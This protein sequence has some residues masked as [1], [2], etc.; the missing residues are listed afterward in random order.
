MPDEIDKWIEEQRKGNTS[1]ASQTMKKYVWLLVAA[2]AGI[3]VVG[4][5]KDLRREKAPVK[6]EED[7]SAWQEKSKRD[8]SDA[9][10][11][12][13]N[14]TTYGKDEGSGFSYRLGRTGDFW[15]NRGNV[16]T[17]G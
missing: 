14:Y 3:I 8:P 16:S 13:L 4:T 2:I 10:A 9:V 1:S 12:V 5:V 7:T 6:N 15:P 11:Q 17:K